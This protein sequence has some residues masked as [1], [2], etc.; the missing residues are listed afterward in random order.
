MT[1]PPPNPR[2]P[3]EKPP[4]KPIKGKATQRIFS[5]LI[6]FTLNPIL[7]NRASLGYHPK[8]GKGALAGLSEEN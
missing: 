1:T 6:Y 2:N 3:E 4:A 5:T 7:G 8:A